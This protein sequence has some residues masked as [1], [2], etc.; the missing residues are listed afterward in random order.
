MADPRVLILLASEAEKPVALDA[1]RV[2]RR[3]EVPHVVHVASAQRSPERLSQLVKDSPAKVIIG[4]AGAASNLPGAVAAMTM[5][6]V[7]GVPVS[8]SVPFD[9]LLSIAQMPSGVPVATVGVDRGD[10]AALLA[11]SILGLFEERVQQALAAYREARR[12]EVLQEDE[13]LQ[14][15]LDAP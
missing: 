14:A 11:A 8:G 15:E 2:L 9:S 1:V 12:E 7:V 10:N 4:V 13:A 3:L 6:P 5:R